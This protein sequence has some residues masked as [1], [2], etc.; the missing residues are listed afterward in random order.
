MALCLGGTT[1][2]RLV[3]IS[4]SGPRDQLTCKFQLNFGEKTDQNF[5][6]F[7]LRT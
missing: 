7:F 5:L 4:G 3:H 1:W 2:S 6:S